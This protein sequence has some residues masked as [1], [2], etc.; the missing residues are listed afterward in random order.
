MPLRGRSNLAD[1]RI[2]FVTTSTRNHRRFF[3]NEDC[4]RQLRLTIA[5]AVRRHHVNLY[6]SV[7]MPDHFQLLVGI[8]SGGPG[9]SKF[10]QNIKSVVSHV[11]YPGR[12]S[13]WSERF[14]DVA[15]Y[16]E[17]LF[18]TK[19]N[20]IHQNPVKAGLVRVA[21][22]YK[23]SSAG[24]WLGLREDPMVCLIAPW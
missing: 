14:D 19:L 22:E 5:E 17:D 16:S 4:R 1:Q 15:V 3:D 9:L 11:H 7:I 8:E 24:A 12:G 21:E 2:F 10:M 13:I 18:R 20:Y 6:G 23:D